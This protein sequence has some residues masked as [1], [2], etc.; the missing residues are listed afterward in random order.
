MFEGEKEEDEPGRPVPMVRASCS[1][2]QKKGW[3]EKSVGR[4]PV[5]FVVR[6]R[7]KKKKKRRKTNEGKAS[8]KTQRCCAQRGARA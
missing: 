7:V 3:N 4:M 8:R 1:S 6:M 2:V 5:E